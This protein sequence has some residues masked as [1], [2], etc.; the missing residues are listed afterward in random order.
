MMII[1]SISLFD[2]EVGAQK[3]ERES[4]TCFWLE[5]IEFVGLG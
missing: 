5:C 2:V 4:E 1:W 3:K